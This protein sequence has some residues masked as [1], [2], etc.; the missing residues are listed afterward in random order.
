MKA[1]LISIRQPLKILKIP[2]PM[3]YIALGGERLAVDP[4]ALPTGEAFT[5][6]LKQLEGGQPSLASLVQL[7]Q[8]YRRDD[9][10]SARLLALAEHMYSPKD[11]EVQIMALGLAIQHG[12]DP[13]ALLNELR[14]SSDRRVTFLKAMYLYKIGEMEDTAFLFTKI[15]YTSG[16][17]RVRLLRGESGLGES[18]DWRMRC[19]A[20][21]T[22]WPNA[23][24][25]AVR[26]GASPSFLFRIG[27]ADTC[28][29]PANVDAQ[30]A[31]AVRAL[32]SSAPDL[33]AI[34]QRL[35][36]LDAQMTTK[37]AEVRY[38]VGQAFHRQN[39]H[40]EAVAWYKQAL[41]VDPAYRPAQWNLCRIQ[42]ARLPF[43]VPYSGGHSA[44]HDY[45][46]LWAYAHNDYSVPLDGCSPEVGRLLR[47][48]ARARAGD[49]RVA[50][51]LI[52]QANVQP[53]VLPPAALFNNAAL[54]LASQDS[55]RAVKLL[56]KARDLADA[57]LLPVIDYNSCVLTKDVAML[58]N[59]PFPEALE[60][61]SYF[62]GEDSQASASLSAFMAAERCADDA[63]TKLQALVQSDQKETR[64][65]AAVCLGIFN[66]WKCLA[67][68]ASKPE[69][70]DAMVKVIEQL[71]KCGS[72]VYAVNGIGVAY[73]V[74]GALKPAQRIFCQ[75][76]PDYPAAR[77][78]LARCLLLSGDYAAAFDLLLA[79]AKAPGGARYHAT[80]RELV[81][82][83]QSP[84]YADQAQRAGVP[85]LAGMCKQSAGQ[86]GGALAKRR[87][88]TEEV[89]KAQDSS[90]AH[91]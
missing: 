88:I 30:L 71:K 49:S 19:F 55:D 57:D 28:E 59:T 53:P 12:R 61:V 66:L 13:R 39:D 52:E 4:A 80:I 54:L 69:F 26:E 44:V 86:E 73:A 2:R 81:G 67:G 45:H 41:Q 90:S 60:Y 22:E 68:D 51:A 32:A 85:G 25:L 6:M 20:T 62:T 29:D 64:R 24:G 5:A 82:I 23:T 65:F 87:Q 70:K 1:I 40:E 79:E 63:Q 18:T 76:T 16:I 31:T 50:E 56:A 3:L 42:Q 77:A 36:A 84:R 91:K 74:L 38:L 83:L 7:I 43:A 21:S 46:A 47:L 33:P 58:E 15:G 17:E 35:S 11:P 10:A 27:A 78:N 14:Y 37:S 75:I 89:P 8:L 34:A 9:A 48:I 72:S